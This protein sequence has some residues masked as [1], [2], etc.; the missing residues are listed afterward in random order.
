MS[1]QQLRTLGRYICFQHLSH[2]TPPPSVCIHR[3]SSIVFSHF[4]HV[5]IFFSA[6]TFLFPGGCRESGLL[7]GFTPGVVFALAGSLGLKLSLCPSSFASTVG[8]IAGL[9]T[10][11]TVGEAGPSSNNVSIAQSRAPV[12]FAIERTVYDVVAV[13]CERLRIGN[14]GDGVDEDEPDE[15]FDSDLMTECLFE[16]IEGNLTLFLIGDGVAAGCEDGPASVLLSSS[17]SVE[18]AYAKPSNSDSAGD[19]GSCVSARGGDF[20]GTSTG[21]GILFLNFSKNGMEGVLGGAGRGV[22]G[23]SGAGGMMRSRKIIPRFSRG[24]GVR[25]IL[26]LVGVVLARPSRSGEPVAE[27]GD[28]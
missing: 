7:C 8:N 21:D 13:D 22:F 3:P 26:S 17:S 15:Y 5:R 23:G 1:R 2:I 19:V 12:D 18:S 9:D 28:C 10:D 27:R 11:D 25:A 4:K 20:G 6:A 14:R 24:E 16:D